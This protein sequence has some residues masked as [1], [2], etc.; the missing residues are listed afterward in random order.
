MNVPKGGQYNFWLLGLFDVMTSALRANN[1]AKRVTSWP[2]KTVSEIFSVLC[3]LIFFTF[4]DPTFRPCPCPCRK[5][6]SSTST[7]TSTANS[8]CFCFC[9]SP[10]LCKLVL[11]SASIRVDSSWQLLP[12][13]VRRRSCRRGTALWLR[14]AMLLE[15]LK[16]NIYI[17]V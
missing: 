11:I 15:S 6:L 1:I 5:S 16:T 10:C 7:S 14:C 12:W 9:S 4:L 2:L 8:I 17:F 13:T 3:L